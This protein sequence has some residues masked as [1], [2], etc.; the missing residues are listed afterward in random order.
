MSLF[1][2][3]YAFRNNCFCIAAF[4]W[5]NCVHMKKIP[6]FLV[7]LF[8]YISAYSWSNYS[9]YLAR[10]IVITLFFENLNQHIVLFRCYFVKICD[11]VSCNINFIIF[12]HA[13]DVFLKLFLEGVKSAPF[14]LYIFQWS[15][16]WKNED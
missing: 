12:F 6:V 13:V 15:N 10:R 1:N 9:H 5:D 11:L 14:E 8:L 4:F 2:Y 3:I 16:Y 7:I